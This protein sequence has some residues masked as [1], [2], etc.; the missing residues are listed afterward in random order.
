MLSFK[1]QSSAVG[2]SV[3]HAERLYEPTRAAVLISALAVLAV[4]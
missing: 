3:C 1:G 2:A 4:T